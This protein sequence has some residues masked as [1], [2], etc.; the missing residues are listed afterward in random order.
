VEGDHFADRFQ[1]FII[2]ALGESI[3]ITGATASSHG[4]SARV[5]VALA[6]AF[7]ITGALWW[8]YFDEVAEHSQRNIAES[9]DP[10]RL[11]RDAYTYL[12]VPIVA[13]IIMVAVADD[14]L[15][16]HPDQSLMT[17]GVVMTV[18]GPAVYLLG[19]ALVRLRMISSLSPQRL[20]VVVALAVLG[21]L[22]AG[23]SA[24]A[25][26]AAVA[27]ILIGLTV[28]DNDR[29]RPRSGPFAWV[30]VGRATPPERL[31]GE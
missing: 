22:G 8:L 1:G 9:E 11:A 14:L 16:A 20:V 15:I 17:A 27:A 6:V 3:V 7:L 19:E 30:S 24:L 10:G 26:S 29:F 5:V 28:W 25:L 31:P 13:G 23:L 12:H 18:A 4:L 21:V 2:I